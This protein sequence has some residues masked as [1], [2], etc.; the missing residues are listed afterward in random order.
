MQILAE[1]P[2]NATLDTDAAKKF[3]GQYVRGFV[4]KVHCLAVRIVFLFSMLLTVLG[5]VVLF[6]LALL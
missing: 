3:A 6:P 5:F 2:N 4:V 1:T